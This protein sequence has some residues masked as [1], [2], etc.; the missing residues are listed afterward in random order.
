MLLIC[1]TQ[2]DHGFPFVPKFDIQHECASQC[3]Y[4]VRD[5]IDIVLRFVHH[6]QFPNS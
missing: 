2:S 5:D 6:A 1:E 4:V 3:R